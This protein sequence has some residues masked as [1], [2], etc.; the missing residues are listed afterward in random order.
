MSRCCGI[1]CDS[2]HCRRWSQ[3]QCSTL[4]VNQS[5]NN[6]SSY[7]QL[8]H[9]HHLMKK[10]CTRICSICK[11][12]PVTNDHVK[13]HDNE[14][15]HYHHSMYLYVMTSD[16][17]SGHSDF[18]VSLECIGKEERSPWQDERIS[19]ETDTGHLQGEYP[20][21]QASPSP[22]LLW[23]VSLCSSLLCHFW[24]VCS[25]GKGWELQTALWWGYTRISL[26]RKAENSL[27][28]PD[29]SI[30]QSFLERLTGCWTGRPVPQYSA[31]QLL[32][33]NQ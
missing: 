11:V 20:A 26:S 33:A 23:M 30:F 31:S 24:D 19:L 14:R 25:I 7:E 4:S 28:G 18:W 32:S 2:Q 21:P 3:E 22:F 8:F 17:T 9:C 12:Q 6:S 13:W 15:F 29:F 10:Y 27:N 16:D 1:G 5:V